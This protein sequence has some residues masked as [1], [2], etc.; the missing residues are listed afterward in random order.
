[1]CKTIK[2]K[3]LIISILIPLAVG[4]LSSLLSLNGFKEF[5]SIN[6]PAFTPPGIL[7]PIVWT[8]L[9]I[10][11]GISSYII[12]MSKCENK[13][14]LYKIYALQLGF[15]FLWSILFFSFKLYWFAFVWLIVLDILIA[16]MIYYFYGCK[17][18][19]GLLQIP[20]LLWVSFAGVL[21]FYIA[22]LN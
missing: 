5:E 1:M 4:G 6:K 16:A 2:L 12:Y 20:Y 21:N 8:I 7:F 17:K 19:A 3:P 15:N 22:L 18:S 11:M 9:Y 13:S 14:F 10:L